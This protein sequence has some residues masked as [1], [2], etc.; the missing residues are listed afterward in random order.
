MSSKKLPVSINVFPT[1][2]YVELIQFD[3][4]AGEIEKAASLPCQF[5]AM[6]RQMGDRDLMLQ[7]IRDLYNMN[8]IPFDTPAV[9]VLPNFFTRE[10]ELPTEFNKEEL[11]FALVSEAERFYIFKKSE[12]QISWINLDESRLLYSAFPKAEIEKYMKIFQ[13]LRIPLMAIELSYFSIFRG[14]VATG[15]VQGEIEATSRWCLLVISDNSFFV[16]IQ[17]GLSISKTMD[18]PLSISADEDMS[19]IQEIQQDFEN[20][21]EEEIFSKLVVVN[22]SNR[23]SSDM[24]LGGLRHQGNLI[25]IEQNGLTL[26]SRGST[27]AQFPC[28]LEGLGGVFYHQFPEMPHLNFLLE[29]SEDV[30]GIL[31]YKKKAMKWLLISNGAVFLFCLMLWGVLTLI[32]WQKDQEREAIS[33]QTGKMGAGLNP[34]Q[35]NEVNRKKFIKTVAE[36]NVKINNFLVKLGTS[37]GKDVWLDKIQLDASGNDASKP[38]QVQVEGKATNLDEVNRLL[39]PLNALVPDSSLEVSNAAQATSLDGQTY[40]TWSIQNKAL[41]SAGQTPGANGGAQPAMPT[42]PP[43]APPMGGGV[44]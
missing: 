40:F 41:D 43:G 10:I 16:S 9:L 27:E 30:V 28:S 44:Q 39:S 37:T 3:E 5:D 2:D 23:V 6:T 7:T 13:E 26:K 15:A 22:N 36:R 32:L 8:R 24:L 31:S 12:P 42:P 1:L 25:L 18:A 17:D 4:R 11:R 38:L 20:F 29:T 19:T 33:Q 34:E 35:I 14:L 21:A